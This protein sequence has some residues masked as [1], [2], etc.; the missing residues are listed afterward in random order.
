MVIKDPGSLQDGARVVTALTNLAE[1]CRRGVCLSAQHLAC[2]QA[3]VYDTAVIEPQQPARFLV[4]EQARD[5][6]PH[7]FAIRVK[8]EVVRSMDVSGVELQRIL[9]LRA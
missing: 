9:G 4:L 8:T 5:L 2:A 7:V 1:L 3:H 6:E